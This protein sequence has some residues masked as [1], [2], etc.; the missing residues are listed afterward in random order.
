MK[1][2]GI[3]YGKR[4]IGAAIGDTETKLVEPLT[5]LI[6]FKTI[7]N[8]QMIKKVIIGNPGG[9]IGEEIERFGQKL[10]EDLNL[11][12]EYFDETLT[13]QDAQKALI[14]SGGSRKSRKQK[15]DAVAASLMLQYYL[16]THVS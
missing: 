16:E 4:K 6:D 2:L 8:N 12:I 1:I 11:P 15:E 10:G 7:I 5:A 14:E 13:T 9:K 3:D